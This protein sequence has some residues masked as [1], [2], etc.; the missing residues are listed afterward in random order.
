MVQARAARHTVRRWCGQCG[1]FT[2][3]EMIGGEEL[4]AE[5]DAYPDDDGWEDWSDGR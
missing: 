5:H 4:C 2:R 1:R 3:S